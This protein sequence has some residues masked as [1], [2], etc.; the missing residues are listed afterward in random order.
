MAVSSGGFGADRR[1]PAVYALERGTLQ[2]V[3]CRRQ[4]RM[5][6]TT[7]MLKLKQ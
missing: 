3:A 5:E 1:P 7:G 4:D 2:V 6:E